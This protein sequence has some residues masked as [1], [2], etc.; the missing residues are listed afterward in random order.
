MVQFEENVLKKPPK[1]T[2]DTLIPGVAALVAQR[3]GGRSPDQP[4]AQVQGYQAGSCRSG[5]FVD[6]GLGSYSE[7][8]LCLVP[9]C[10]DRFTPNVL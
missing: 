9:A 2:S 1:E 4:T 7:V 10:G 3:G 6:S 5:E 8:L